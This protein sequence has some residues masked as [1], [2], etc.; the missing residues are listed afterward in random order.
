M[1]MVGKLHGGMVYGRR[2][3]ILADALA[4]ALPR[5]R[6]GSPDAAPRRVL[7]VGCGDGLI[8]SLVQQRRP[9]VRIEG[10][11]ILR[12]PHT[13]IPVTLFDGKSIPHASA[14]FD[15]VMFVDVLHHTDDARI[16]LREAARVARPGGAIVLK[17]HLRDGVLAGPT[18]RFMDWVG[19]AHHGV[20]LPY[21]YW[22]RRQWDAAWRDLG[23]TVES[24]DRVPALYPPYAAWAFGRGLHF[25]ARL[26][27][28][29][30]APSATE[31]TIPHAAARAGAAAQ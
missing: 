31:V 11:E 4:A 6:S 7:D 16:L 29:A 3:R 8:A 19:N 23:L 14:G 2:V 13:H 9:D 21:N 30:S 28:P 15:A 25:V 22:S 18:L 1:S 27:V 5:R 26:G 17:D 10:I 12:R 20:R 24:W